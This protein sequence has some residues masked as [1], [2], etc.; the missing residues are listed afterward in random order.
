[1]F[2]MGETTAMITRICML[3]GIFMDRHDMMDGVSGSIGSRG[4]R[5]HAW[6]RASV[7]GFLRGKRE[8]TIMTDENYTYTYAHTNASS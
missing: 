6:G 8:E 5:Y 4:Y 3:L 2:R 1:M 7:V